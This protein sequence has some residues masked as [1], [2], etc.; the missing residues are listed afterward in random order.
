MFKR[1]LKYT[2]SLL[3]LVI[4]CNGLAGGMPLASDLQQT[5]TSEGFNN[6]GQ[7]KVALILVSQPNCNY[8]D[9]ITEEILQPMLL[10]GSYEQTTLFIEVETNSG[11]QLVDFNG[12]NVSATK[13]A[14]R[15]NAWAT[16]TLLFLDQQ[17]N[18]IAKKMVGI[19]TIELYGFYVDKALKTAFKAINP[20]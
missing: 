7:S 15:Y 18:E 13:F 1:M 19:N 4:S 5:Y 17:G 8:C 9:L 3:F 12:Q 11:K 16:P 10:N 14:Q 6:K 20:D 2:F